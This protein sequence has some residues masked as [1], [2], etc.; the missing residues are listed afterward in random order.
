MVP[1]LGLLVQLC[2]GERGTLQSTI[3]GVCGDYSQYMDHTGFA[4]AHGTCAFLVYTAQAHSY[5]AG[6]LSKSDPGFCPIPRS[7]LLRFRFS[8]TPQRHKLSWAFCALPRSEHLRR[9][10]LGERTVPGGLCIL[11]TSWVPVTQ[12]PVCASRAPSQVGCV[13]W[14]ADL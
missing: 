10:V 1:Y 4:P 8:S 2:C 7:E 6:E 9:Q 11:I 12:F 5:S 3:T 14:G 13:Y